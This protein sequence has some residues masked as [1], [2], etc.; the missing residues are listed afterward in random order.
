MLREDI[1]RLMLDSLTSLQRV[2]MLEGD[3]QLNSETSLLGGDSVL[4]SIAFVTYITDLEDR[5]S[6]ETGREVY[7]VLND[8][9][10][11]SP[12]DSYLSADTLARHI[13]KI[14]GA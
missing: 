14:L 3:V 1:D 10:E 8:I 7:L 12:D 2:G 11:F 6:H 4:D 13:M 9:H 5:L